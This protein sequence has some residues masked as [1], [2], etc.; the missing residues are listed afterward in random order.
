MTSIL[1]V[2]AFPIFFT[3][4]CLVAFTPTNSGSKKKTKKEIQDS[5]KYY[6]SQ[7]IIN[8]ELLKIRNH[9]IRIQTTR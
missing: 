6:R 5:I 9:G 8:Y 7:T 4:V 2:S 3:L 1:K